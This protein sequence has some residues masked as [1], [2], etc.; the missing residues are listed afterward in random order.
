MFN[1]IQSL[2]LKAKAW[3]DSKSAVDKLTYVVAA[4]AIAYVALLVY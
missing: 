4:S 2:V 3:Y 1:A